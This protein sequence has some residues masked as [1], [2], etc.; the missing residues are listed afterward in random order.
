MAVKQSRK[1]SRAKHYAILEIGEFHTFVG[2]TANKVWL[3]AEAA[4]GRHRGQQLPFAPQNKLCTK[5]S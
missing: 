4:Y 1:P 2:K 3:I 5:A